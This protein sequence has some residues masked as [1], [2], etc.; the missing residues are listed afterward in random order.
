MS[1]KDTGFAY[2]QLKTRKPYL[3]GSIS[4]KDKINKVLN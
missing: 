3:L 4:K 1:E 2:F